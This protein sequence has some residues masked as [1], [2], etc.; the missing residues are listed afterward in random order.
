V[1]HELTFF[2]L[3]RCFELFGFDLMVDADW[4]VWLL[5]ANAEPDFGQVGYRCALL[6]CTSFTRKGMEHCYAAITCRVLW[7]QRVARR[8]MWLLLQTGERL[9][10][11]VAGVVDGTL[12]LV[13]DPL[14][15]GQLSDNLAHAAPA[16]CEPA[17]SNG[18]QSAACGGAVAEGSG[19]AEASGIFSRNGVEPRDSAA[20]TSAA[21][22]GAHFVEVF[23]SRRGAASQGPSGIRML[24]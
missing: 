24:G 14:A 22:T 17:H 1:S 19:S 21:L 6:S 12:Q 10:G 15:T 2:P 9:R 18:V 7:A 4:R 16:D 23:N 5:E 13:A 20:T 3:P 8:V 11:L